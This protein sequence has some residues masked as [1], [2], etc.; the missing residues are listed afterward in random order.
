VAATILRAASRVSALFLYATALSVASS[1]VPIATRKEPV[2][3]VSL[4]RA[5]LLGR[6]AEGA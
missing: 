4:R 2:R 6:F 5:T 1:V 3:R